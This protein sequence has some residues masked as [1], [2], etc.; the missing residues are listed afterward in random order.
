MVERRAAPNVKAADISAKSATNRIH[1]CLG[2]DD[3][4]AQRQCFNTH[5][6]SSFARQLLREDPCRECTSAP[7]WLFKRINPLS[8]ILESESLT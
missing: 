8:F 6:R 2:L 3:T 4:V 5:T 7:H 1:E